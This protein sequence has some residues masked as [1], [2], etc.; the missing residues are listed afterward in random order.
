VKKAASKGSGIVYG[1]TRRNCEQLAK[2]ISAQLGIKTAAYHAGIDTSKRRSIQEQWTKGALPLV[3]ATTAFG[4]GIDKA[5]CRYVIHYEMPYSLEAYYQQ[6]GRAGRDG[7]ESYPLLLFKQPDVHRATKRIKDSYPERE[8]LQSVYDAVCDALHLAVGVAEEEMCEISISSLKKRTHL[9]ANIIQ[10]SLKALNR[11]GIIEG[12]ESVIPQIGIRFMINPDHL[13]GLIR[14]EG[15]G[16]KAEFLDVLHR[17]F[18]REAFANIK[19]LERDYIVRKLDTDKNRLIKGLQV[20]QDHD[21]ILRFESRGDL[22]LIRLV[23]ARVRTLSVSRGELEKQ[24]DNLLEKLDSMIGY[25]E[26]EVCREE[27]IRQYFGESHTNPC[28][29]CDN[30]LRGTEAATEAPSGED[31]R[32]LR[33][34]L[35]EKRMSLDEIKRELNWKS[36]KIKYVLSYLLRENKIAEE[37][38][39]Y[40]WVGY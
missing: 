4:M 12:T 6:A 11:L 23:K 17:Q 13:Q 40:R 15:N 33:D 3:T 2:K 25:I 16:Q 39:K 26:T 7:N 9:P 30:C 31:M 29:H 20:L 10:A 37:G 14:V 34:K 1:G 36:K 38:E 5:D 19:Y 21:H 27:Y 8:Q 22:P 35:S 28:G 18:G 32:A 24:R